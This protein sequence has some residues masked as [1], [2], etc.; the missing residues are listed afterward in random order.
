MCVPLPSVPLRRL[1]R[2]D[3]SVSNF[4]GHIHGA[5]HMRARTRMYALQENAS[6]RPKIKINKKIET[7]MWDDRPWDGSGTVFGLGMGASHG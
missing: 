2:R 7:I 4:L 5:L 1:N 3:E 6:H